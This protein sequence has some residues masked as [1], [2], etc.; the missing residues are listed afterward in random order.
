MLVGPAPP[1]Q[2]L[3]YGCPQRA[4]GQIHSAKRRDAVRHFPSHTM[5][6][7]ASK[8]HSRGCRV[9]PGPQGLDPV[10]KRNSSWPLLQALAKGRIQPTTATKSVLPSL[11]PCLAMSLPRESWKLD[12]FPWSL[13]AWF[14]LENQSEDPPHTP[15]T[16]RVSPPSYTH[17]GSTS[18]AVSQRWRAGCWAAHEELYFTKTAGSFKPPQPAPAWRLPQ[19]P[20]KA[21]A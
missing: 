3:S 13:Q 9:C 10:D 19:A 5:A 6:E 16:A 17:L 14:Q 4:E 11:P 12:V 18:G 15:S 7:S 1:S 8:L 2:A 21:K 20:P